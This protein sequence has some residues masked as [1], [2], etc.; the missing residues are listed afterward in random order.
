MKMSD[1]NTPLRA[2]KPPSLPL[3]PEYATCPNCRKGGQGDTTVISYMDRLIGV[4]CISC[5]YCDYQG[6]AHA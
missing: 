4:R 1:D 2:V 5:G 3:Q 6:E